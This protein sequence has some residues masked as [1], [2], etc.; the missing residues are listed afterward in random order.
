MKEK[1]SKVNVKVE[2]SKK[3]NSR[4]YG[5]DSDAKIIDTITKKL[6]VTRHL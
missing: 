3:R 4:V 1:L 5:A 2:D 6:K